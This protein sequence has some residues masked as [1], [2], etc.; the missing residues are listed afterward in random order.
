MV[1]VDVVGV[2]VI[3][4]T[5]SSFF[6]QSMSLPVLQLFVV[7]GVADGVGLLENS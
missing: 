7:V 4:V 2:V 6:I 5:V 1:L 3:V